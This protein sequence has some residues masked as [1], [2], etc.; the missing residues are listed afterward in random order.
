MRAP[1][2]SHRV[3]AY[4]S[5]VSCQVQSTVKASIAVLR[6]ALFMFF[7]VVDSVATRNDYLP[8]VRSS[9]MVGK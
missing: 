2:R 7:K 1:L 3:T 5:R 4:G 6:A 8:H 9:R